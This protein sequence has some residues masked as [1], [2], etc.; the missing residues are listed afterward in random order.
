MQVQM[1]CL[2]PGH[3]QSSARRAEGPLDRDADV[4]GYPYTPDKE[5]AVGVCPLVDLPT[6]DDPGVSR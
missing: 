1:C 2:E 4:L 5:V 3:D 6:R